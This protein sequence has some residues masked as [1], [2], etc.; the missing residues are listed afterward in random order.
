MRTTAG[1]LNGADLA[2]VME[3][4]RNL[5][6]VA[7][8][9]IDILGDKQAV[10]FAAS[11]KQAECLCEIFN[12]HR[13]GMA[14]W[15]CGKTPDDEREKRLRQYNE[16]EVQVV[17]NCALL[18]EGW[19]SPITE[20]IIGAK[21]TKS[22]IVYSQQV[23]RGT[24]PLPG[25]V[26]GDDLHNADLRRMAIA[27]SPK[28]NLLLIDFVGNSGKH[29]LMTSA[30]ILGGKASEEAMER[31]KER[32]MA[33][34]SPEDMEQLVAEEEEAIIKEREEK[35]QRAIANRARLTA[36]AT[37][38]VRTVN[39][40]DAMDVHQSQSKM[41]TDRRLS[42][43]QRDILLKNGINPEGMKY[44]D[45][46]KALLEVFRRWKFKLASPGQ[47]HIIK[48]H[49]P[50]IDTKNLKRSE[51]SKIIDEIAQKEGWSGRRT[52]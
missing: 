36:K 1:D 17:V 26:D 6:A 23:G 50:N 2:E 43:A 44:I 33:S 52:T 32:A 11:V 25:V 24:R 41:N 15:V 4:E 46:K 37:F 49:N 14:V 3:R 30:D 45:A 7:S 9:S 5:H 18:G 42:E 19:D 13:A 34:G 28:K 10:A 51:A 29:K 35:K 47:C 20:A 22:R 38:S 12:R 16:K 39:P 40:F 21:P 48:K 27:E 31:A 8:A